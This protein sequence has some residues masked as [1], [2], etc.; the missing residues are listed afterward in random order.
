M[1]DQVGDRFVDLVPQTGQHRHRGPGHRFGNSP[2]VEDGEIG[3]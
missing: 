1:G 2:A 3:T